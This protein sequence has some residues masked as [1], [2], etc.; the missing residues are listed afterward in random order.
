[1]TAQIRLKSRAC[2]CV[3][4]ETDAVNWIVRH[5]G[6]EFLV[7]AHSRLEAEIA[8][9]EWRPAPDDAQ[10]ETLFNNQISPGIPSVD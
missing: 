5:D 6:H 10:Q 4:D 1:M 9:L 3:A 7:L 2:Q 8:A